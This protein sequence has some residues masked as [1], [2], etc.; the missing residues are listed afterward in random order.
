[1][2]NKTTS[3]EEYIDSFI[4]DSNLQE[5][6]RS[7]STACKTI[8][9]SVRLAGIND[10]LGKTGDINVQGEKVEK[11]DEF[12]NNTLINQ[13]SK[14]K[15]VFMMGSEE[16]IVV[17]DP[18]DGS[19]N[20][21]VSISIGTIFAIYKKINSNQQ[22]VDNLL[23]K[24]NQI[25]ASGYTVYGSSTVLCL[26]IPNKTSL[27][28]LSD[29]QEF[30]LTTENIVHGNSK[31]YSI[32]ESNWNKFTEG[33]KLWVNKLRSGKFGK[34]TAR[35][36]GSLVADFHRNLIKGGVFAYPA[37]PKSGIGRLR[38]I[39]ECNPLAFIAKQTKGRATDESEDILD[40]KPSALHQRVGLYIGGTE[41]INIREKII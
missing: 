19:S 35:Y 41:E 25:L 6:I 24:G 38:L 12:A 3:L 13:L 9:N 32:N 4:E 17:F 30:F 21:D 37:D 1:M 33:N 5:V 26:S 8:S 23:Q 14:S 2:V 7:I 18:L 28:T 20:I 31:V 29:N 16:Y 40:I 10:L 39:Y 22:D 27:F 36:V 11:L 15:K 34:Y